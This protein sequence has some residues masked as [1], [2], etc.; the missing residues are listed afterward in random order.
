MIDRK[1]RLCRGAGVS[2][3]IFLTSGICKNAGETP[4]LQHH[5]L[6]NHRVST[7]RIFRG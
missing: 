7:F 6:H 1:V 3:A 5:A 2:P 4:A